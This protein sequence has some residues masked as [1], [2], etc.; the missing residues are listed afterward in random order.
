MNHELHFQ[1][2][3]GGKG[4]GAEVGGGMGF[5]KKNHLKIDHNFCLIG[6]RSYSVSKVKVLERVSSR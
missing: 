6:L 3:F 2:E 4:L 1:H 5:F